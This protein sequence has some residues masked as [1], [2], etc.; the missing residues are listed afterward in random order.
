MARAGDLLMC[1]PGLPAHRPDALAAARAAEYLALA[2]PEAGR[3][4]EGLGLRLR[5]MRCILADQA[6]RRDAGPADAADGARS[7]G[8]GR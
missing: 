3:L 5:P 1:H 8:T 7:D 4:I 2:S 6:G